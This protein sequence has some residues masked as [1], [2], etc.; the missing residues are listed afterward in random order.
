MT[1]KVGAIKEK[2]NKFDKDTVK[3]MKKKCKAGKS[4]CDHIS[5]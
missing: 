1:A 4:M 2:V 3:G 5:N